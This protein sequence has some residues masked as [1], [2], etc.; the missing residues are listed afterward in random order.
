MPK[1]FEASAVS[2]PS[3]VIV[4]GVEAVDMSP[5]TACANAGVATANAIA[6]MNITRRIIN[7]LDDRAVENCASAQPDT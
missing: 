4:A 1:G 5:G 3:G 6:L 7:S 2:F